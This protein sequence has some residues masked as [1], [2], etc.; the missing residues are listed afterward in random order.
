AAASNDAAASTDEAA[1]V[2]PGDDQLDDAAEDAKQENADGKSKAE[3]DAKQPPNPPDEGDKEQT[4]Q[5]AG[6][7]AADSTE[8]EVQR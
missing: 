3:P 4:D 7:P 6:V 1:E 8:T 2:Q 5:V